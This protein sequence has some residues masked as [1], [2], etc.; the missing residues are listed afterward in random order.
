MKTLSVK[1]SLVLVLLN[2]SVNFQN[3]NEIVSLNYVSA[4]ERIQVTGQRPPDL[5][6]CGDFDWDEWDEE[7]RQQE[8]EDRQRDEDFNNMDGNEDVA[9]EPK[10]KPDREQCLAI[11]DALRAECLATEAG[12]FLSDIKDEC[13]L[14]PGQV[15]TTI[16]ADAIVQFSISVS[17]SPKGD[18]VEVEKADLGYGNA[19][20]L[21]N[22]AQL[23][24][25]CPKN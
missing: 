5:D 25:L 13:G 16:G 10:P 14:L 3:D 4:T 2:T 17:D 6:E 23:D 11:N 8:E 20:C 15:T 9:D 19:L 7:Q 18:C 22:E 21:N 12:N 1:L 24:L